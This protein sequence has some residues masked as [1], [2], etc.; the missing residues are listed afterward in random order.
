MTVCLKI[1]GIFY[2]PKIVTEH[3][4]KLGRIVTMQHFVHC[5][6]GKPMLGNTPSNCWRSVSNFRRKLHREHCTVSKEIFT[7]FR[8]EHFITVL[9][10]LRS[11]KAHMACKALNN[12]NLEFFN[13]TFPYIKK[14]EQPQFFQC[15]L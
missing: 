12:Q 9:T 4:P 2:P 3:P 7:F 13:P 10:L 11:V 14:S 6:F 8:K 1:G 15:S 5:K